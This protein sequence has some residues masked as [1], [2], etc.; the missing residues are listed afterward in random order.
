ML[1]WSCSQEKKHNYNP[2]YEHD[3]AWKFIIQNINAMVYEADLDLCGDET[4]AGHN[5]FGEIRTS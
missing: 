3:Y 2:A 4:T 5:T 1:Q